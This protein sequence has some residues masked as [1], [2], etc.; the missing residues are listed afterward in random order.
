M[1]TCFINISLLILL[2]KQ[3]G[4]TKTRQ[5]FIIIII[6]IIIIIK[7][8]KKAG[9]TEMIKENTTKIDDFNR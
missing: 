6:I 8:G 1:Y 9:K 4:K 2:Q 7:A 5:S 3:G